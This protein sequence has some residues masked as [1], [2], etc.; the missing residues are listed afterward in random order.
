MHGRAFA[1]TIHTSEETE[2]Q[3]FER[4]VEV[5][6]AREATLRGWDRLSHNRTNYVFFGEVSRRKRWGA[7]PAATSRFNASSTTGVSSFLPLFSGGLRL[8]AWLAEGERVPPPRRSVALR[9]DH[10]ELSHELVLA[11]VLFV[12]DLDHRLLLG[13]D[14]ESVFFVPHGVLAARLSQEERKEK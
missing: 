8:R 11:D 10:L 7:S 3:A 12:E 6:C 9:A 13:R 4:V 1:R 2:E 14:L 5:D